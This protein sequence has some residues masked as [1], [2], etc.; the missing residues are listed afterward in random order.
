MVFY[1]KNK[2]SQIVFGNSLSMKF[3]CNE[4]VIAFNRIICFTLSLI[5]KE[6]SKNKF[7]LK[8]C[9]IPALKNYNFNDNAALHCIKWER[10]I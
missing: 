8:F 1:G 2:N 3:Y 7:L 4:G 9:D 5:K 6:W 10:G